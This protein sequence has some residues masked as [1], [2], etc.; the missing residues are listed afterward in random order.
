MKII[1]TWHAAVEPEYRKLFREMANK[2][3]ELLVI[4]PKGWTEG[5]R[6]Q[7][8]DSL[9]KACSD[10]AHNLSAGE[11]NGYRLITLS[12][13]FQD[14]IKGFFYPEIY[15]LYKV[16]SKFK[17]DI[18][19]IF[20]EPYSLACFEMVSFVR[21]ASLSSKIVV[22]SFENM[23]INQ[24][25]PFSLFERFILNN[26]DLLITV[27]KEG[28]SVWRNKGYS[29]TIRQIPVGLDE[30]LF[31]KHVVSKAKALSEEKGNLTEGS[32][33]D[34][35]SLNKKGKVRIAY[36]GRLTMEKGISLLI[37]AVSNLLKKPLDCELL[38]IGSGEKWILKD[39]AIELGV[40]DNT[41]FLDAVPNHYLP[42][43]YSKIDI[44]VLPSLTTTGWKEQ[45]G[46]VLIEAMA[47]GVTVVGSSSGEIPEI[48]GD[49]G[50]IFEKGNISALSKILE[51]LILDSDLRKKLGMM[52]RERVLQNFTWGSIAERL[53]N[54]YKEII[55]YI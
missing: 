15:N 9:N 16:F 32:F 33:Q 51:K 14:R 8:V 49:A 34:F 41:I 26:T 31:K 21:I 53:C 19:H 22:Q 25:F 18:V 6:L 37:T 5:G 36:I 24:R 52:G 43:I 7:R 44:L 46:R 45:F 11:S 27:P 54:V 30:N 39:L 42:L 13:I 38:I 55:S 20:E 23:I 4:C 48:I 12:V 40:A 29:G 17:P 50:L 1:F 35:D 10:P 47:C 3:H 28:E 2:G